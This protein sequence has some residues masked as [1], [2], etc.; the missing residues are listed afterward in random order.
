MGL[1]PYTS[2]VIIASIG[3]GLLCAYHF[4]VRAGVVAAGLTVAL[5]FAA[6]VMPGY[7]F[8]IYGVVAVG[9]TG[10]CFVGPRLAR[11]EARPVK[12]SLKMAFKMARKAIARLRK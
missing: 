10:I 12:R 4:G 8:K 11:D 7:A 2:I 6:L 3:I 5:L 1:A 9:V